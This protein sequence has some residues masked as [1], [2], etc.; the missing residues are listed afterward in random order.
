MS[1]SCLSVRAM[2]CRRGL[3]GHEWPLCIFAAIN[4]YT[5]TLCHSYP[6]PQDTRAECVICENEM[7][8]WNG[9]ITFHQSNP[10]KHTHTHTHT[11]QHTGSL[12]HTHTHTHTTAH[13]K[14]KTHGTHEPHTCIYETHVHR[15][16]HICQIPRRIRLMCTGI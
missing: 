11:H 15:V 8:I 13:L 12:P 16:I 1:L 9:W 3:S 5:Y 6:H 10:T 4:I 2:A 14:T 7:D